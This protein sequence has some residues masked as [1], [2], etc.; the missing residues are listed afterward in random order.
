MLETNTEVLRRFAEDSEKSPNPQKAQETNS[1]RPARK[2]SYV[3]RPLEEVDEGPGRGRR[4]GSP[5][6]RARERFLSGRHITHG[7]RCSTVVG[8]SVG[9][10]VCLYACM[11]LYAL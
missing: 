4:E 7:T 3:R 1:K 8:M 11:H 10:Y 6:D 9:L 5:A 2:V